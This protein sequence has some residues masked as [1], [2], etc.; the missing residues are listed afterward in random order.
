MSGLT[1][2][3]HGHLRSADITSPWQNGY[4]EWLIGSILRECIDQALREPGVNQK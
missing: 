4:A 1:G 3:R 2:S